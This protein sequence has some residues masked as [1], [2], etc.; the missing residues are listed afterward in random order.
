MFLEFSGS[1]FKGG[2]RTS[3]VCR[4]TGSFLKH[5]QSDANAEEAEGG[6]GRAARRTI[7]PF[8]G[9]PASAS[10]TTPAGSKRR[11]RGTFKHPWP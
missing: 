3:K 11:R 6:L 1:R 9:P 10:L 4:L 7:L 2:S 5:K 8:L